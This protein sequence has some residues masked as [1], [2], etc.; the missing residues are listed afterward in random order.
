MSAVPL[1][2]CELQCGVLPSDGKAAMGNSG[3][4]LP[5]DATAT[6]GDTG[7]A[8]GPNGALGSD[9]FRPGAVCRCWVGQIRLVGDFPSLGEEPRAWEGF[10]ERADSRFR[11]EAGAV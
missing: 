1:H 8:L 5:E 3:K 10:G 2:P 11:V 6:G 4:H 9:L 7:V